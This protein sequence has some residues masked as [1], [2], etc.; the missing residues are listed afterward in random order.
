MAWR[1]GSFAFLDPDM[2]HYVKA[3]G[4]AVVQVRGQSP[5]QFNYINAK[6]DPSKR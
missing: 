4:D 2:H 1:K 6:D 5:V 3:E